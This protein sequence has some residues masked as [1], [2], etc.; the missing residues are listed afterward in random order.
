MQHH[1]QGEEKEEEIHDGM[2]EDHQSKRDEIL[3]R[4]T[5]QHFRLLH[6]LC[7]R[8]KSHDG[9]YNSMA[10]DKFFFSLGVLTF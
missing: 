4:K 10:V 8:M 3:P 7:D 9:Y 2:K 1:R 5:G 6:T